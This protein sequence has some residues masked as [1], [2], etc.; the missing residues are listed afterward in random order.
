MEYIST[1]EAARRWGIT[2]RRVQ[3]YCKKGCIPGA[4]L[5]GNSWMI[6]DGALKP[7]E[8][9]KSVSCRND[10]E[11]PV[12]MPLINSSF[13]P[14]RCHQFIEAMSSGEKRD[15]AL[16]EYFY[17]TG[18]PEPAA[19]AAEPFLQHED[20]FV[21][22][23]ACIIYGFANLPQGN[24]QSTRFALESIEELLKIN[25][26]DSAPK[27]TRAACHFAAYLTS[28]LLH[29]PL[30]APFPPECLRYLPEGIALYSCYIMAHHAYLVN[31]YG[32]SLGIVEAA[33][34]LQREFYPV[35]AIYLHL[36]AAMDLMSLKRPE[37]A[38]GHFLKAWSAAR[39]DGLIE[40]LAEH[41]GLLE[42][43]I[44]ICMKKDFPDD[45]KKIIDI[46][47]RFSAGWRLIHNEDTR[48]QVADNLTTMEFTIAMLASRGWR[49]QEIALYLNLSPNTIKYYI[50]V[51]YQKLNISNRNQLR[52]YMLR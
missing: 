10:P 21:R 51:V 44:E 14:G 8:K 26:K 17:F 27:E 29:K 34:S 49:N 40:G 31:E 13:P 6:P 19:A 4:A 23:S 16:A 3:Q 43:L 33:L 45:Y 38:R 18:R 30:C 36:V 15:I 9:M 52:K 50:S 20:V 48:E 37:E 39:T 11:G 25:D 28:V 5:F 47:Y 24:T 1:K 42:G 41:H 7:H 35:P 2:V 12:L 46:T 32:R 22:L